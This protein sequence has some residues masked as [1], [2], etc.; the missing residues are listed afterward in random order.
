MMPAAKALQTGSDYVAAITARASDRRARAAFRDLVMRTARPGAALFEFGAGPGI[1][2][3]YYA[4]RGFTVGAYD[5]D[6]GMREYFS[7]HCGN[8][9]RA[10]R[11]WLQGGAYAEFLAG[12]GAGDHRPPADIVTA[13]FAPLNLVEDLTSLFAKFHALTSPAGKVLA[14]VL[15]PYFLADAQYGWWWRNIP[16][17]RRDGHFSVPGAQ[18]PIIRRTPG[19]FAARSAPFFRLTGVFPAGPPAWLPLTA[20]RFM[21]LLFEKQPTRAQ[22]HAPRGG[23]VPLD[24]SSQTFAE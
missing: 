22:L 13:N 20:S 11:I 17:L 9:M 24:P 23:S 4:E 3:R 2:A 14:S 21:F 15:S 5:L 16:R 19:E 6:P 1:D 12:A 7:A 10:G 8:F 18:G